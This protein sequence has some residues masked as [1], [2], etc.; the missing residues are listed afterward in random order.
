MNRF[1]WY[2]HITFFGHTSSVCQKWYQLCVSGNNLSFSCAQLTVMTT[3]GVLVAT[4]LLH[5]SRCN[6]MSNRL[7]FTAQALITRY[8]L[9]S[10]VCLS[11][12]TSQYCIKMD[13]HRIMP[14]NS[15]GTLVFWCQRSSWNSNGVAPS[16]SAKCRWGGKISDFW[17]ITCCIL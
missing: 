3:L 16:K 17:Q 10:C 7:I 13:E 9:S 15:P 4:S 1:T 12:I 11:V 14:H 6:Y 5:V 8:M 2:Y